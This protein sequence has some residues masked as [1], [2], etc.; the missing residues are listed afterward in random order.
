[1]IWL[2]IVYVAEFSINQSL[3]SIMYLAT[4]YY[5]CVIVPC[6]YFQFESLY[7]PN[8]AIGGYCLSQGV[9]YKWYELSSFN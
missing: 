7:Y 9:Q 2:F 5:C 3:V 1:M 6:V 4:L 8:T